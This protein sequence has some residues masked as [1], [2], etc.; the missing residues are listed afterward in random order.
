[1]NEGGNEAIYEIGVHDD[2]YLIG[3]SD[4]ELEESIHTLRRMAEATDCT[5]VV[6]KII[7]GEIGLCAEAAIRRNEY[8]TLAPSQV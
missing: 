7:P 2:G 6:L 1:M 3:L 8:R 4:M 5:A